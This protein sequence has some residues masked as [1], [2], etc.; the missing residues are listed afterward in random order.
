MTVLAHEKRPLDEGPSC[1]WSKSE[2]FSTGGSGGGFASRRQGIAAI[3]DMSLVLLLGAQLETGLG[4]GIAAAF[5]DDVGRGVGL[6]LGS[7]CV[8]AYGGQ[9]LVELQGPLGGRIG[10][11]GQ[12]QG[13]E[14]QAGGHQ[15]GFHL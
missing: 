2:R 14:Q 9:R 10:L 1:V 5:G 13:G 11:G 6:G 3:G 8:L 4:H 12:G 15:F 7:R